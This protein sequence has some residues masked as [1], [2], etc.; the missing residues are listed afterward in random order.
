MQD[1]S[2]HETKQHG[3]LEFPA[4]YYYIDSSHPRYH[5]SFHWHKEWELIYI[6][7]GCFQVY[8]GEEHYTANPG[9]T[10]LIRDGM[11]HGG[12]PTDCI[13]ECFVFDLHNLFRNLDAVKKYLR[14][15]YHHHILPQIFYSGTEDAAISLAV[16]ELMNA[17]RSPKE[18][19]SPFGD[20]HELVTYSNI[21]RLFTL[22]LKQEAYIPNPEEASGNS[23]RI[24][25]LKT[26]LEY[27]ETHYASPVSLDLL[28]KEAGMNP[29]YFCRF[30][31]S[32]TH[33][34]PLDYV[35]YYRIQQ[36]AQMLHTSDLSI[37]DIS[38]ECGFNDS[39][40]FV[41]VFR[42]YRGVTPNQYR[43]ANH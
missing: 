14:P 3:T 31:R 29:K 1:Y 19:S 8:A 24:N 34:T 21:S 41:K 17:Y 35:N 16:R 32:L 39:S 22:I 40:Y 9:D 36:A 43:H 26:V 10:I 18:T 23:H 2:H 11:L 25:Q 12:T 6:I 42:K 5:M 37:T 27:I 4:E 13:Y 33:Q 38:L 7:E 30:F 28:A 20:F 15:I